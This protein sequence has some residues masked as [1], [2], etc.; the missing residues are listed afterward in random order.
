M[1]VRILNSFLKTRQN[2]AC[3]SAVLIGVIA[4][5]NHISDGIAIVHEWLHSV[6]H[7]FAVEGINNSRA[8]PVQLTQRREP[9]DMSGSGAAEEGYAMPFGKLRP[10]RLPLLAER[11]IDTDRF[12]VDTICMADQVSDSVAAIP[13]AHFEYGHPL[14]ADHRVEIHGAFPIA[15]GTACAFD[16]LSNPLPIA[17]PQIAWQ[18]VP[19]HD[20][21]GD[22]LFCD[23]NEY[24][25]AT[26]HYGVT[27]NLDTRRTFFEA[28]RT[29]S[30]ILRCLRDR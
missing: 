1:A 25:F 9:D 7:P 18:P 16:R 2:G 11:Q 27:A 19:R 6:A 21:A 17:V 13:R 14:R 28:H 5:E 15:Q 20:L 12:H 10:R 29:R 4:S 8:L 30:R 24:D 3:I 22:M 26:R 23:A